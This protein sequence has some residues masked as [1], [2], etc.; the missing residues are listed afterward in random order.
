MVHPYPDGSAREAGRAPP[1]RP[2]KMAFRGLARPEFVLLFFS[3]EGEDGEQGHGAV[4]QDGGARSGACFS[5]GAGARRCGI[6]L[7]FCGNFSRRPAVQA[8]EGRGRVRK[9]C[10]KVDFNF[11][12]FAPR[13]GAATKG[14]SAAGKQK[15]AEA[16]TLYRRA[17]GAPEEDRGDRCLRSRRVAQGA[18]RGVSSRRRDQD[19][20]VQ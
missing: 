5:T 18:A 17:E 3:L 20:C 12:D 2:E 9:N 14:G 11:Q 8:G 19:S 6:E 4:R 10:C 16:R 1:S 7:R 15:C 13:R